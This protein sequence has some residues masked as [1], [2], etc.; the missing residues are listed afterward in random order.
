MRVLV[1]YR[2]A[3]RERSGAGEYT[4][5]L[6]RRLLSDGGLDVTIFSSSWKDRLVPGPELAGAAV[7][8][9]RVPVRLLNLAWHRLGWPHVEELTSA[10][11]VGFEIEEDFVAGYGIDFAQKYRNLS[12]L[13]VVKKL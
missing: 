4:H 9:R 8:D 7:V 2:P 13:V 11:V 6:V 3:L 10:K 5:Q 12:Q 1:D